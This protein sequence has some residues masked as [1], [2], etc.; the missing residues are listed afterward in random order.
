MSEL[1]IRFPVV[2]PKCGNEHL[3]EFPVRIVADALLRDAGI[4]L[5]AVCHGTTWKASDSELDQIRQ[6]LGIVWLDA[7][8]SIPH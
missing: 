8:R 6:Y 7:Q 1:M 2:C 4:S 3:T 5:V